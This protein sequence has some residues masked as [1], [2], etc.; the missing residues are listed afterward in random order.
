M[1]YGDIIVINTI[2]VFA[3][4]ITKPRASKIEYITRANVSVIKSTEDY[5]VPCVFIDISRVTSSSF[6]AI[7]P[8][9]VLISI[10]YIYIR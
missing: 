8:R 5:I 7:P 1:F 9:M 3:S 10:V 4:Q 6:A 2:H